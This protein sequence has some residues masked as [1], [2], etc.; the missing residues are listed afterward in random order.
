[1]GRRGGFGPAD[2]RI[3]CSLARSGA[4]GVVLIITPLQAAEAASP[5]VRVPPSPRHIPPPAPG[6]WLGSVPAGWR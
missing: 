6:S 3:Y 1:M 4:A 5:S 2:T